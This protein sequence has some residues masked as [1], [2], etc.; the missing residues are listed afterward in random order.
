MPCGWAVVV[1]AVG[2]G[3]TAGTVRDPKENWAECKQSRVFVGS[4]CTR[5]VGWERGKLDEL[6]VIPEMAIRARA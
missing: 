2:P 4:G 3:T 1:V 5:S 6:R